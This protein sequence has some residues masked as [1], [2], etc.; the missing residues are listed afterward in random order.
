MK[1]KI[2]KLVQV[3]DSIE[4]G[5]NAAVESW[6]DLPEQT[7]RFRPSEDAWSI[8]EITGHLIDSA[9]NNH[10]RFIRLQ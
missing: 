3:A 2:D 4:Q 9:A 10:Q 5:V 1:D 6:R 8:K 7:L